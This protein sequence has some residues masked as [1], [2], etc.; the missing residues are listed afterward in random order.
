MLAGFQTRHWTASQAATEFSNYLD[1]RWKGQA[2]IH[3]GKQVEQLELSHKVY[4]GD[5]LL[6]AEE[7]E[8]DE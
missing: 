8:H 2:F 7:G 4:S 5:G 1:E 6:R 3:E